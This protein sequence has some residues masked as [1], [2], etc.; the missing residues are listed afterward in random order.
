MKHLALIST[1]ALC[2]TASPAA[3]QHSPESGGSMGAALELQNRV[4]SGARYNQW[5]WAASHRPVPLAGLSPDAR[6]WMKDEVRRQ[7]EFPR[8]PVAIS[9]EMDKALGDDIARY[10]RHEDAAPEQINRAILVNVMH[11]TRLALK[12]A[13]WRADGVTPAGQQP[14]EARIAQ[15]D[16]NFD[17]AVQLASDVAVTVG[18]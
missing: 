10:A 1:L 12:I 16:A 15:A 4:T 5:G 17:T 7:A 2:A 3:A 6:R 13:A 14:W 9:L 11:E 8:D 18:N